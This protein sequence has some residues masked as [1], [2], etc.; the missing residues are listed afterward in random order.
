VVESLIKAGAFD[1][2]SR[3]R[4]QLMAG[5]DAAFEAGQRYQRERNEGQVSMFDLIGGGDGPAPDLGAPEP[6]GPE[7]DHEELLLHEKEVLG[8]YLSGH[9][10]RRVWDRARA[11]GAAGIGELANVE[12]G[13]RALLCGLVTALREINTKNGNRMGFVTLEDVE[14]TIEVTVFPDLFRQTAAHLKSGVPLLIRGRVEGATM[15]R[16]LL[17]D[18]VRPL[19]LAAGPEAA[20]PVAPVAGT[21]HITVRGHGDPGPL[22]ALR[23]LCAAHRGIVAVALHLHVDGSEVVVRPRTLRIRPSPGFVQAVEQLLGAESVLL[24]G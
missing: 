15:P 13:G 14:G 6:T 18:E 17:A 8:F 16:K 11:L 10:L 22:Q 24:E 12:D 21:C 9:P 5:L 3:A 19:P 4:A 23:D 7:W 1:S 2:L 20:P